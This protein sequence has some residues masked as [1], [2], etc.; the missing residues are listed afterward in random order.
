MLSCTGGSNGK[1]YAC[2]AGDLCLIPGLGRSPGGG[3][4]NPLLYSCL[5]NPPGQ[6]SLA[7]YSAWGHEE[8]EMT[9]KISTGT[10]R[11]RGDH[12]P[13]LS[14]FPVGGI[15]LHMGTDTSF[16]CASLLALW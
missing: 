12:V 10:V 6:R 16:V 1:E 7:G 8:S 4:D 14:M 9:E 11:A 15:A 2:H 13:Y 3:H 5:E